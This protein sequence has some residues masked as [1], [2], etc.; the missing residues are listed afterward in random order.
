MRKLLAQVDQTTC[1]SVLPKEAKRGTEL[2]EPRYVKAAIKRKVIGTGR[3][4]Y[5]NCNKPYY[6]LHHI[7]NYAHSRSHD[8]L[9]PLCKEHHEFIHNG[10]ISHSQG[11]TENW[12]ICIK[13]RNLNIYD[14]MYLG[15][16]GK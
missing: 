10:L 15:Y 8:K 13:E 9:I 2:G 14:A 1:H 7:E 6:V 16:S 11:K 12:Q 5:N 4:R 3:C